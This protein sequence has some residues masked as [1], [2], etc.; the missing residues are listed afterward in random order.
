MGQPYELPNVAIPAP[1]AEERYRNLRKLMVITDKIERAGWRIDRGRLSEFQKRAGQRRDRFKSLFLDLTKLPESALKSR[2]QLTKWFWIDQNA[3]KMVEERGKFK[4]NTDLLIIY[5]TDFRREK[6]GPAAAALYGY[7]K[8]IKLLEFL[9]NYEYFSRAD[10]RIHFQFN[11]AG[12]Q[13]GR[14]VCSTKA[15][16]LTP[17]GKRKSIGV[18][19]QQVPSKEPTFDFGSGKEKLVESLRPLFVA[20]PG[21]CIMK[22]DWDQLELRLIAYQDGVKKLQDW[23]DTNQDVHMN[24]ARVLFA[25]LGIPPD[26]KKVKKPSNALEVMINA[27]RDVVKGVAYNMA[28]QVIEP[29]KEEEAQYPKI[30]KA[31]KK[32]WPEITEEE[33]TRYALRFFSLHPEIR[34]GQIRL[35]EK[36]ASNGFVELDLDGR[37]LYYPNNSRG[38]NQGRNFPFQGTGGALANRAIIELDPKL[39]WIQQQIRAQNHDELVVQAPYHSMWE[40]KG[41]IE[42]AMQR[43]AQIGETYAGIPASADPGL[44]WGSNRDARDF[45]LEMFGSAED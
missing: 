12:T 29:G 20:D 4:F 27:A 36:L 8:N 43:P 1:R 26:A 13:T 24:N 18:N 25:E 37:R 38:R 23:I 42:E 7:R 2:N 21:C 31:M 34:N 22:A 10:G 41:W 9:S 15:R 6:F 19:A 28:Y 32:V 45:C 40:V 16:I 35:S 5:A 14:W 33:S 30:Y 11:P 17:E 44:D 3:P 39:D